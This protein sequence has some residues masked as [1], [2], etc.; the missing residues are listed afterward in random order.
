MD[1]CTV[2]VV[3]NSVVGSEERDLQVRKGT[4]IAKMDYS[5]GL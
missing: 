4:G 1:V 5:L 3:L 2:F